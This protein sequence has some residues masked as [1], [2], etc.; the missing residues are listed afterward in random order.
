M[1]A[2]RFKYA[3]RRAGAKVFVD[4]VRPG[5]AARPVY[6]TGPVYAVRPLDAAG[7]MDATRPVDAARPVDPVSPMDAARPVHAARPINAAKTGDAA[8]TGDAVNHS[9][10]SPTP[11]PQLDRDSSEKD[12]PGSDNPGPDLNRNPDPDTD[13]NPDDKSYSEHI[14][15][16]YLTPSPTNWALYLSRAVLKHFFQLIFDHNY[17]HFYVTFF[18]I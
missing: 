18:I 7:P 15:C 12:D 8:E 14:L 3:K 6:A 17:L 2:R 16:T 9:L 13:L 11:I 4:A 1:N 5:Y 10:P